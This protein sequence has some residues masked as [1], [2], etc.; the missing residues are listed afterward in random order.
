MQKKS[1]LLVSSSPI[2]AKFLS[3]SNNGQN[4]QQDEADVKE[5]NPSNQLRLKQNQPGLNQQSIQIK[6]GNS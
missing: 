1:M 4:L 5:D 6:N 2:N 3:P